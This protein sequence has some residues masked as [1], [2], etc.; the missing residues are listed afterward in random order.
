MQLSIMFMNWLRPKI[1]Q[2]WTRNWTG[3]IAPAIKISW[4]KS[5]LNLFWINLKKFKK[6]SSLS[7][8]LTSFFC[9]NQPN[10][11]LMP[12]WKRIIFLLSTVEPKAQWL[13]LGKKSLLQ[14]MILV[15]RKF[16][17]LAQSTNILTWMGILMLWPS[18]LISLSLCQ[19]ISAQNR[20]KISFK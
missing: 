4:T 11:S 14:I 10:F 3:W 1:C 20:K 5:F 6:S 12:L 16:I 13:S 2:K 8:K 18:W 19:L 17:N 9:N 7:T 15:W